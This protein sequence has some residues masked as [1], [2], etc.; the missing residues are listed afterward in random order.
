MREVRG[1]DRE[2]MAAHVCALSTRGGPQGHRRGV[3]GVRQRDRVLGA[4]KLGPTCGTTFLEWRIPRYGARVYELRQEGY[5][6]VS[7]PCRMHRH[8]N[9]QIVY[10]L[11]EMDQG[12]LFG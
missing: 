5:E 12:R 3:L 8:E 2:D 4:L 1:R 11:T 10:E 7:R 9:P 6:I